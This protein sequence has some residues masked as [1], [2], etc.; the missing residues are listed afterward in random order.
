MILIV[1]F[2]PLGIYGRW[3]KIKAYFDYF[4]LYRR[5]DVQAPAVL[6]QDGARAV[7]R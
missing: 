4:P 2:E 5:V 1:L 7:S 6:P 3:L